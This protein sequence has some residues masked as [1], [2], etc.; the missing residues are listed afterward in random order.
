MVK[1]ASKALSLALAVLLNVN[2]L[3]QIAVPSEAVSSESTYTHEGCEKH[4]R[5]HRDVRTRHSEI[6]SASQIYGLPTMAAYGIDF[7]INVKINDSYI[8]EEAGLYRTPAISSASTL[9]HATPIYLKILS[10]L[11]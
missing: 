10:L 4:D 2:L 7:R 9:T 1:K 11:I 8:A 3:S 5:Q 6:P